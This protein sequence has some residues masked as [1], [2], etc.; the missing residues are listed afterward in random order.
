MGGE[1]TF[2]FEGT[3]L[4]TFLRLW[5]EQVPL[6]LSCAAQVHR[7]THTPTYRHT[8]PH[9]HHITHTHRGSESVE[10][11]GHLALAHSLL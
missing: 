10:G 7:Q 11:Q 6:D 3:I 9:R 8:D 5:R 1:K 4:T 2:R